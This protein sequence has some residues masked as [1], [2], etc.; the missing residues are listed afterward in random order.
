MPMILW[1]WCTIKPPGWWGSASSQLETWLGLE[2]NRD[3]TRVVDWEGKEASLNLLGFPRMA[4]GKIN[5]YVRERLTQHL[6]RRSQRPFRPPEGETY[7][8]QLERFG[9]LRL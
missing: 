8:Q 9:L 3:K 6:R 1:C 4:F 2:I 5:S 7:Y